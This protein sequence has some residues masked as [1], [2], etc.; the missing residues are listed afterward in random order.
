M[1]FRILTFARGLLL[2]AVLPPVLGEVATAELAVQRV[3]AGFS[4]PVFATAPPG[5]TNRLFVV[6]QHTGRIRLL[7]LTTLAIEG[8]FLTIPGVTRGNEQGLLGLAFHPAYGENGFLYVNYTTTGG[9]PAGQTII[10][11]YQALGDPATAVAADPDSATVVLAFDQPEGNHNGGWLGF[12]PDG[13]LYISSGDGGG[14]ND[15]HGSIGSG[16]DRSRLLGKVLRIDVNGASPYGVP[17]TNP[18]SGHSEWRPE[19]WA[20]GLR[21]PWRCSLDR[22]TGDLWIGDVGQSAREEISLAPSGV[23]GL[24][25][26]WRPREGTIQ[27]PAYDGSPYP[28]EHPVTDAVEP[29]HDYGR[30]LGISVTGGYVYRGDDI[31]ALQGHYLFAD[32]GSARF[33]SLLYEEG[34]VMDL[35]ERTAELNAGSPR[36]IGNV[37][38]FGE[39]ARG[40]LYVCDLAD[41]EVYRIVSVRP[42]IRITDWVREGD[43][44]R[45]EF[46]G[47][48]GRT[49]TV[50]SSEAVMDAAWQVYTNV[51]VP[52]AGSATVVADG[53]GEEA[54]FFRVVDPGGVSPE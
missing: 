38:S 19:I 5:D 44:L 1:N 33:W 30:S 35:R 49:Y 2:T 24:N 22:L 20:F 17:E 45:F 16:Q 8:T 27:N 54:R 41:G 34:Q 11:R 14:S 36:P 39:D 9:G 37:A 29:L 25:F 18:F 26:G 4:R 32:Y 13:Y 40:E 48:P 28:E 7:N 31:P 6:E 3:G 23:G 51:E 46:T 43:Q 15:R 21:N 52:A 42:P 53:I 50:L 47:Q 10:A 12:G